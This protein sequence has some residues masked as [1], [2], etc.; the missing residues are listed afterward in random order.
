[1]HLTFIKAGKD[2]VITS[3]L[4]ETCPEAYCHILNVE[5]SVQGLSKVSIDLYANIKYGGTRY[6]V[7]RYIFILC[8]PLQVYRTIENICISRHFCKFIILFKT[9]Q[10]FEL[11]RHRLRLQL[12]DAELNYRKK[13]LQSDE[14]GLVESLS[15]MEIQG[16]CSTVGLKSV[17]CTG[18][19]GCRKK[20]TQ[21]LFQPTRNWDC[22]KLNIYHRK[23]I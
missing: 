23:N 4:R 15:V 1:M 2:S 19:N 3:R 17:P 13:L 7:Y 11:F 16:A 12:E 10:G 9:F 6:I 18:Q 22:G 14:A 8:N 20:P 21:V 5:D